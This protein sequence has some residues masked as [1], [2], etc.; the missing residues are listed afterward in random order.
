ML[1]TSARLTFCMAQGDTDSS[2]AAHVPRHSKHV[3]KLLEESSGRQLPSSSDSDDSHSGAVSDIAHGDRPEPSRRRCWC[4]GCRCEVIKQSKLRRALTDPC[5]QALRV[6][7]IERRQR[8]AICTARVS[9]VKSRIRSRGKG[10]LLGRVS[11][12]LASALSVERWIELG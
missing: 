9:R 3:W 12:V 2:E 11:R 10:I 7:R 8:R 4:L 6:L 1:A 5:A